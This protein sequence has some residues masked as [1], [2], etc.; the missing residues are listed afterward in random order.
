MCLIVNGPQDW[1]LEIFLFLN[2]F[3]EMDLD[4]VQRYFSYAGLEKVSKKSK[5]FSQTGGGEG[6]PDSLP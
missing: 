5:E 4:D 2:V 1:A 3:L 6:H